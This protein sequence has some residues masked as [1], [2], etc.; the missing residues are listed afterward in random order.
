[1]EPEQTVVDTDF[2]DPSCKGDKSRKE[3][4]TRVVKVGI[5]QTLFRQWKVREILL[6]RIDVG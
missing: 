4:Q 3:W 6:L 5:E 1:M 2:L